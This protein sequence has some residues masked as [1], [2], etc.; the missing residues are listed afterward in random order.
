MNLEEYNLRIKTLQAL[1]GK[2]NVDCT[3]AAPGINFK[4]ALKSATGASERLLLAI[5]P[6]SDEA[7]LI[8]PAFEKERLA[9]ESIFEH[10]QI[11]TWEEHENPFLKVKEIVSSLSLVNKR[12]AFEPKMWFENVTRIQQVLN[13][14]IEY[15]SAEFIYEARAQKTPAEINA[16]TRACQLTSET[17]SFAFDN[18][19]AGMTE[20]EIVALCK[21]GAD[22]VGGAFQ[23]ALVQS[24]PNSALPHNAS[25]ERKIQ[26]DEVLLIDLSVTYKGYYGDVTRMYVIGKS[27]SKKFL[28]IY[29]AVKKANEV[30][31]DNAKSGMECQAV[32]RAA[33]KILIDEGFGEYFTHRLGHGLGLE[34]H[35]LPYIVEGNTTPLQLGATHTVEPGVY[36]PGE[37]GIR[38]EDD[39]IVTEQGGKRL[40]DVPRYS[41]T[42]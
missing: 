30:G 35:E 41:W 16:L 29:E 39:I 38:I 4:Y 31:V 42:L 11:I 5:L 18:V 26:K 6:V 34:V 23:G 8:C 32:D 9:Q 22:Q 12:I 21:E 33:R 40:F 37:F 3:L 28:K 25:S 10:D 36:L 7:T 2:N 24:G 20:L 1:M 14:N 13:K 17:I 19:K 15:V 27:P